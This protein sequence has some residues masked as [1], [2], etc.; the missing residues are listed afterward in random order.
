MATH[1]Y[2]LEVTW[3]GNTGDGTA[4]Y[5][6]YNRDSETTADGPPTLPGSSDPSFRG[7]PTRWNPE[8][9]LVASVAQCHLLWYL[10]LCAV[11]HVVVT[12]YTDSPIGVMAETP[13]G[14]GHFTEIV[15]HPQVTVTSPDMVTRAEELHAQAHQLCFIANSVNF[16][17]THQPTIDVAP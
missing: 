2:E 17:I 12:A 5:R 8:Q 7:D 4:T 15:L 1:M 6:S 10:H 13:D 9:L 16:P 14:G 11:N 3:T